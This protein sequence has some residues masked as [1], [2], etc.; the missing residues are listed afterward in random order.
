MRGGRCG[1]TPRCHG[2]VPR[3]VCRA[4][5]RARH[6]PMGLVR[7]R[8][9]ARDR[10]GEACAGGVADPRT[11]ATAASPARS[12]GPACGCGWGRWCSCAWRAVDG[13]RAGG[14][15]ARGALRTTRTDDSSSTRCGPH[16][17][18]PRRRPPCRQSSRRAGVAGAHGL[19]CL[20]A[21]A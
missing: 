6:G 21:V 1:P 9:V 14:A 3:A 13:G 5:A 16:A 19:V 18:A 11:V 17:R 8:A 7:L 20:R 4:D 15:C 12:V 10:A 2:R